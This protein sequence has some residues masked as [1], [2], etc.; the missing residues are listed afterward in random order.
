MNE[1]EKVKS[2]NEHRAANNATQSGEVHNPGTE[3][4]SR[5]N[6]LGAGST[7]LATAALAGLTA[8]AQE[9]Q[10]TRK[11]DK[12][13]SASDPGQENKPLVEENPNSNAPPPTDSGIGN[14]LDLNFEYTLSSGLNFGFGYARLFAGQFLK[15]TTGGNDYTYPYAYF[16]YNFSK[17]GF[18]FPVRTNRPN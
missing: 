6:F 7:A 9:T 18:H 8:H 3:G 14:E 5:R 10:D 16:Q 15:T 2:D 17:S 4:I 13:I 1:L 11:A 12:D